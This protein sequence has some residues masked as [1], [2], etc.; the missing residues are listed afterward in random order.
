MPDAE[1]VYLFR[2]ALVRDAAYELFPP[3]ERVDLHRTVI[4]SYEELFADALDTHAEELLQHARAGLAQDED[5]GDAQMRELEYRY[6]KLA[7]DFCARGWRVGDELRYLQQLERHPH[8]GGHERAACLLRRASHMREAGLLEASEALAD[9]AAQLGDT[10]TRFA[11]LHARFMI[12]NDAGKAASVDEL[13]EL[14]ASLK[15]SASPTLVL[16]LISRATLCSRAAEHERADGLFNEAVEAAH[17]LG[18]PDVEA[19]A[20]FERGLAHHRAGRSSE[21]LSSVSRALE[22]AREAGNRKLEMNAL[23]RLGII[24][25]ETGRLDEAASSYETAREIA[26]AIGAR[27]TEV[28]ISNNYANLQFYFFGNLS[29][30]EDVYLRSLEFFR[31]HNEV[32]SIAHANGV[33]GLMYHAAGEYE[34]GRR[35]FETVREFARMQDDRVTEAKAWMGLAI[36]AEDWDDIGAVMDGYRAAIER[37]RAAPSGANLSRTWGLLSHHLLMRGYIRA[38]GTAVEIAVA[39]HA[40]EGFRSGVIADFARR[41]ALL[42]GDRESIRPERMQE[43]PDSHAYGRVLYELTDRFLYEAGDGASRE[44]LRQI[45]EEIRQLAAT[46]EAQRY[47]RVRFVL[48]LLDATLSASEDEPSWRGLALSGLPKGLARAL[49]DPSAPQPGLEELLPGLS[50]ISS[51]LPVK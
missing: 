27:S 36:C 13:D 47:E 16:A 41:Y 7:A 26:H 29:V 33:L 22:I 6:L 50:G 1:S 34:K 43:R 5:G 23:N 18:H 10:E 42:V 44:R 21:G 20:L 49:S 4:G 45:G 32:H 8:T 38:A 25:V 31:E 24:Y 28:T 39:Q 2:H 30:A 14:L 51:P 48:R 37:L 17:A 3:A 35:C 19:E 9:E 12:R 11:A 15:G 40:V 46:F